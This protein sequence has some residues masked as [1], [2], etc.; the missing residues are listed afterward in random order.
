MTEDEMKHTARWAICSWITEAMDDRLG[1]MEM[2][3]A[4]EETVDKIM[5]LIR[6]AK[7][8]VTWDE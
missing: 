7:V 5:A 1:V 2:T 3:E 6:I 4:D 8:S